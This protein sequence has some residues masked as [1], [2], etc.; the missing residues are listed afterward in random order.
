MNLTASMQR[1]GFVYKAVASSTHVVFMGGW[2][3]CKL[4]CG[5]TAFEAVKLVFT[6]KGSGDR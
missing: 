5:R 3:S 4:R 6:E 2:T 1:E